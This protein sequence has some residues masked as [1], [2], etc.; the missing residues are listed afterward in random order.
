[1]LVIEGVLLVVAGRAAQS[2][3]TV[4]LIISAVV[5]VLIVGLLSYVV[6]KNPAIL[7]GAESIARLAEMKSRI[8]ALERQCAELRAGLDESNEQL[9]ESQQQNERL[10]TEL[11]RFKSL[12]SRIR[13]LLNQGGSV[14]L[15]YLLRNLKLEDNPANRE[16]LLGVL[17]ALV[18]EREIEGDTMKP[19]GS[20]RLKSNN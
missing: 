10:Q 19:Q 3:L 17:G 5:I 16:D 7:L 1:M 2:D 15:Q 4:V 12:E 8:E 20:Y 6:F 11:L 14:D 9:A 18:K 13:A